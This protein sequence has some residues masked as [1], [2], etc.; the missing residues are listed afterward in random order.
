MH[1]ATSTWDVF[2][3]ILFVDFFGFKFDFNGIR[4]RMTLKRVRA[5]GS[6][7]LMEE[8]LQ[9]FWSREIFSTFR[10]K[11]GKL[12]MHV[13]SLH[14]C[15]PLSTILII[16]RWITSSWCQMPSKQSEEVTKVTPSSFS[17]QFLSFKESIMWAALPRRMMDEPWPVN[18]NAKFT[19]N[20]KSN[21]FGSYGG[22]RTPGE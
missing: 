18:I 3:S 17:S 12:F 14:F 11:K 13:P 15:F 5:S 22:A 2:Q 9:D 21:Q 19:A 6:S 10:K 8:N 4:C 7:I 20:F 16:L 1:T